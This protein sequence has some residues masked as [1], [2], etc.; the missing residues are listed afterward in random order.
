MAEPGDAL[1]LKSN[2]Q[3]WECGFKSH[4]GYK[5]FVIKIIFIYLYCNKNN[6]NMEPKYFV[7]V[8]DK[9]ISSRLLTEAEADEMIDTLLSLPIT[10]KVYRVDPSE[11]TE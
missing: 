2:F 11:A 6:L 7:Y 10:G 9:L 3:Q 1:D 8:D 5:I 4:W